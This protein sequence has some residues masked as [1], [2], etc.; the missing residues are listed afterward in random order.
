MGAL[1]F[2]FKLR[3]KLV[4]CADSWADLAGI[5]AEEIYLTEPKVYKANR[6]VSGWLL[7]AE[8]LYVLQTL[9]CPSWCCVADEIG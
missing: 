9:P 7:V 4:T 3:E 2:S 5:Q 6:A 8:L 1:G